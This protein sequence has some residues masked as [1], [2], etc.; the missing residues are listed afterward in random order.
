MRSLAATGQTFTMTQTA[1]AAQVHQAFDID[2]D[3]TA[4][5]TFD[6]IFMVDQFTQ[7]QNIFIR[8]FA[9]A[10]RVFD[11]QLPADFAG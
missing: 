7:F 9:Y 11:V 10:A 4:Q 1:I 6:M 2:A 5:F 8:Q 3:F